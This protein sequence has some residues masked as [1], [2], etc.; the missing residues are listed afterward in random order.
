[1]TW[2]AVLI[3]ATVTIQRM[4]FSITL[5]SLLDFQLDFVN[6]SDAIVRISFKKWRRNETH[7]FGS[8]DVMRI[9]FL[10][11]ASYQEYGMK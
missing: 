8:G 7:F 5:I 1:M 3:L 10:V 4:E 2:Y 9:I 6:L 11:V